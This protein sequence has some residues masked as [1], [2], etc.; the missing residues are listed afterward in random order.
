M[1]RTPSPSHKAVGRD[2]RW[3][4]LPW[5][6]W[7]R[8][9]ESSGFGVAH[10]LLCGLQRGGMGVPLVER[11]ER[12]APGDQ[13]VARTAR[14]I[15]ERP[16]DELSAQGFAFQY[17]VGELGVAENHASEADEIGSALADYRL[18]DV[19]QPLLQI[20]ISRTDD[21]ELRKF[22]LELCHHRNLARD[23]DE[24]ILGRQIAVGRREERRPLDVRIVVGTA[25]READ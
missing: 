22:T 6:C 13:A 16:A 23:S 15:T 20:A 9:E 4:R 10:R 17:V 19:R 5:N 25:S 14:A 2:G 8:A 7:S 12:E 3:R 24:R 18:G 21:G 11:I 1:R